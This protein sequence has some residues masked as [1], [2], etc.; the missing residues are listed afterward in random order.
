M[1]GEGLGFSGFFF[2]FLSVIFL[3]FLIREVQAH[4]LIALSRRI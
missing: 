1:H 3:S 4:E 2:I